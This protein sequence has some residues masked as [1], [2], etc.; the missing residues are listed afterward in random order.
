MQANKQRGQLFPWNTAMDY[1]V[2]MEGR[3]DLLEVRPQVALQSA[4]RHILQS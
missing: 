2:R 4:V 1:T 3:R